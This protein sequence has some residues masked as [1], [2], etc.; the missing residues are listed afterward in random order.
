MVSIKQPPGHINF[1]H[2]LQVVI[3]SRNRFV[4]QGLPPREEKAFLRDRRVF[5]PLMVKGP[6][7][8][9]SEG[10]FERLCPRKW[11]MLFSLKFHRDNRQNAS[12]LYSA[13]RKT[14]EKGR[15]F[16]ALWRWNN[17]KP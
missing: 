17:H 16:T 8:K 1:P 9:K 11:L 6:E 4:W 7:K 5:C 13:K 14:G 10:I 12:A 3:H 15:I 2:I